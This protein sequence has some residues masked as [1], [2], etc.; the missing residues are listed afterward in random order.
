MKQGSEGEDVNRTRELPDEAKEEMPK[1]GT[2]LED[3]NRTLEIPDE[4]KEELP[5][6]GRHFR[7]RGP[8]LGRASRLQSSS[9]SSPRSSCRP[10]HLQA[11]RLAQQWRAA[12]EPR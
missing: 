1:Q 4:A 12:L 10:S 11:P 2:M 5:K 3:V 6:Q 7:K 9:R 8:W